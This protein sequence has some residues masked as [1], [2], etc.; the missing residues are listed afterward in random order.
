M[1]WPRG[2]R[3]VFSRIAPGIWALPTVRHPIAM[4]DVAVVTD[5]T[6]GLPRAL[7]ERLGITVVSLYYH[8][9]GRGWARESDLNGDYDSLYTDFAAAK[10]PPMTSPPTTADFTTAFGRLLEHR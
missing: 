4:S 7:T 8:L 1:L 6:A 10:T 5:S 3:R 9:D 2:S